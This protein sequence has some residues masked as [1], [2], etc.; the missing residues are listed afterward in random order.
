MEITNPAS[1]SN[2]P[3]LQSPQSARKNADAFAIAKIQHQVSLVS[4]LL[5]SLTPGMA[6]GTARGSTQRLGLGSDIYTAVG[7]QTQGMMSRGSTGVQIA[8]VSLGIDMSQAHKE[9]DAAEAEPEAP[10]E[11]KPPEAAAP[12][13]YS[14]PELS[15][16]GLGGLLN[17]L[18]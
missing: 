2:Y 5:P 16:P 15:N 3:A 13:N 6:Q 11:R 14:N 7:M 17:S 10:A 18:G 12:R 1:G 4:G 8:N 9:K